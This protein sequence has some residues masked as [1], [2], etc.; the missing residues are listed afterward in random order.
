MSL[1]DDNS[2]K[3]T[4]ND[5]ETLL[6][7]PILMG[8]RLVVPTAEMAAEYFNTTK[9]DSGLLPPVVRYASSDFR[10]FLLERP[11]FE[12]M[13]RFKPELKNSQALDVH[14]EEYLLH[15]PWTLMAIRFNETYSSV[16]T[17]R[18]FARNTPIYSEEDEVFSMPLPNMWSNGDMCVRDLMN[19]AI[20]KLGHNEIGSVINCCLNV[21]W[22]S[23]FNVDLVGNI[24]DRAPESFKEL[25]SS[26]VIGTVAQNAER[27][28]KT[29]KHWSSL[30]V[31]EVLDIKFS[32]I[33]WEEFSNLNEDSDSTIRDNM[34]VKDV[35]WLLDGFNTIVIDERKEND[36]QP[37]LEYIRTLTLKA[38]NR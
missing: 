9:R 5:E 23:E 4:I 1:K 35:M 6:E 10:G 26:S 36:K 33:E 14:V 18:L 29:F 17:C 16:E 25:H 38:A 20:K 2:F 12:A 3:L 31:E 7:H 32:S 8:A 21:F 28:S 11:P 19:D 30:S 37:F 15:A 27:I 24:L 34:F 13:I 22:E